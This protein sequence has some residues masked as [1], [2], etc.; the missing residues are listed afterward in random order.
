M[1]IKRRSNKGI[2][3]TL[4][5]IVLVVL[6]VAEIVTFVYLNINYETL[7]TLGS[8]AGGSYRVVGA[9]NSSTGVFL[10]TSL[11][12]ALVALTNYE[13]TRKAVP[14]NS[15]GYA[16]GSL[17][18]NGMIYGTN[19]ISLMAGSTL[20]NYTN[21]IIAQA[22]QQGFTLSL[23]NGSLQ[24]YQTGQS[25]INAT[26]YM[27]AVLNSSSGSFT[28]PIVASSGIS[29]NGSYDLY[30][31]E[32]GDNNRLKFGG[33]YPSAVVIGNTYATS[34]SS[35]PFQFI[36]GTIIY[37]NT[38]GSCAGF[39]SRFE[40]ANFILAVPND[41]AAG[42][43]GFGGVVTYNSAGNYNVPY[44][45]YSGTSNI[46]TYLYNGTTVLLNGPGHALLN[47]S[48]LQNAMHNGY[49]F[50]SKF[51]P[52]YMDWAQ[53]NI[54]KRSQNGLASF[55]IYN[56]Q[57]L[58]STPTANAYVQVPNSA[59]LQL[60][61]L[62][63]TGWIDVK[64]PAQNYWNWV[65]AKSGAW[66]VGAC[67]NSFLACYYDWSTGIE[68]DSNTVLSKN[69]WY[70]MS[71]TVGNGN[72][73]IYVN[74]ANVFAGA[75]SVLNQ[76]TGIQLGN[77]AGIDGLNGTVADVQV[78]NSI[79]TQQ[80]IYQLYLN[81]VD[82]LPLPSNGPVGYWPLDGNPNDYSGSGYNGF[83]SVP[84]NTIP[85]AYISGY[86]GDPVYDGS[87]YGANLTN[88][89]EGVMNCANMLQCSN[90]SLQQL[91]LSPSAF[92]SSQ[93]APLSA[94]TTLGL[95]NAVI[96]DVAHFTGQGG[97]IVTNSE[98]AP[99]ITMILWA[100][101]PTP[102]WNAN[103]W[104][105]SGR[106]AEGFVIYPN[107]GAASV[108]GYIYDQADNLYTGASVTP[109][110]IM[111]W[112]QYGI[113]Y[114]SVTQTEYTIVN[115]NIGSGASITITRLPVLLQTYF[116]SDSQT[117]GRYGSGYE[118]DVQYYNTALNAQQVLQLYQNDSIIGI[119]PTDKWALSGTYNGIT[120]MTPDSANLLNTA[121]LVSNTYGLCTAANAV[122]GNCGI[123]FT[124]P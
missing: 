73:I 124:Q 122:I 96:P 93:N 94:A 119:N 35:S 26:Y 56:K 9:L 55:N 66:G 74:G 71:A 68:H 98:M 15:T 81:G 69:T 123:S 110:N 77:S 104:L 112:N 59:P 57:V 52:A 114:N 103:G 33:G 48:A 17:M 13:S 47:I 31:I 89:M 37:A 11:S 24:I 23:Y 39:P 63:I 101:S 46:M 62:T 117:A 16:L 42:S 106:G 83:V 38:L 19:E 41:Q 32:N 86:T 50:S 3:L 107:Q 8:G 70:F 67:G 4:V 27:L 82:A 87:F 84:A 58:S 60:S 2:L 54:N 61:T 28:Y 97:E 75:L 44:L 111:A 14:I 76:G 79:L 5:V 80:Q 12:S 53:G 1:A 49:Y 45:V 6:M 51:A 7:D 21:T 88:M 109:S 120:N 121:V 10:H 78:Y 20:I 43:C 92:S 116:G 22:K 90:Q 25:S 40:N 105:A 72:E 99:S 36:Y 64:G 34:G 85:Y 91:Y 100:R 29:V 118:A 95:A 65:L 115:G 102:T 30:S 18:N 108:T 113:I